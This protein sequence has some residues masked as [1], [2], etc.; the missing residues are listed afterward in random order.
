[1]SDVIFI[2]LGAIVG[3]GIILRV[4]HRP[5]TKANGTKEEIP[6]TDDATA[7]GQGC[8]GRHAVCERD[9]LIAGLDE[10]PVYF[11]DEELDAYRGRKSDEYSDEETEQFRDVLMTLLPDDVA[12]WARSI[13][14]RGIE[15]PAAVRDELL[16][17]VEDIRSNR[18]VTTI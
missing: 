13:A 11:D 3:T 14:Q 17:I 7:N 18:A 5:D 1:M 9:S 16:M 4:L 15:L 6:A 8:C 10:E 2:L 12:P